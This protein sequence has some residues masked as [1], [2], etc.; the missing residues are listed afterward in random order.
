[1]IEHIKEK[2]QTKRPFVIVP[3]GRSKKRKTIESEQ[4]ITS[5]VI[6][7]R[8][9]QEVHNTCLCDALSS[10]LHFIGFVD[11]AEEVHQ[12]GRNNFA[13]PDF[14][15]VVYNQVLRRNERFNKTFICKK[16]KN[17]EYDWKRDSGK[18]GIFLLTLQGNDGSMDHV[19]SIVDQKIF[20]PNCEVALD[21]TEENLNSC[22]GTGVKYM[23]IHQGLHIYTHF[24][25]RKG[26]T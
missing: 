12:F 6:P 22:C 8:Y 24:H 1:L 18:K 9:R 4:K 2:G 20:D 13:T 23:G 19:V 26:L 21:L 11:V 3:P 25:Y 7:V 14:Y 5:D 15:D 16:L 17:Q 10:A